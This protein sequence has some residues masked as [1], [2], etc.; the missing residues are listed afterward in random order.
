MAMSYKTLIS[1]SES[2]EGLK[3]VPV[4]APEPKSK[5][6]QIEDVLSNF[7]YLEGVNIAEVMKND[8]MKF[9]YFKKRSE[10][11]PEH[12]KMIH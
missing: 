1:E 12:L 10:I 4:E 8:E 3:E 11:D 5:D 6:E 7:T 2:D 9:L